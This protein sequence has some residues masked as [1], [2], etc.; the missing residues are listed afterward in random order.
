MQQVIIKLWLFSNKS[1]NVSKQCLC[2]PVGC[3]IPGIGTLI[4][5]VLECITYSSVHCDIAL[6][7]NLK[8]SC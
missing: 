1:S 3:G 5:V 4:T 2:I 8:R 7:V 6:L